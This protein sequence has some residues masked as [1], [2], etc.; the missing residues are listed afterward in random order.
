MKPASIFIF[1][2]INLDVSMPVHAIPSPGQDVYVDEL[3][4]HLG[5]SATN[6]AIV[7]SQLG[8]FPH[9]FG[10]VGTDQNGNRLLKDIRS[11]GLATDQ[12]IRKRG[13]PSG[14]IFLTILPDGERSMY[15][16]RGANVC[17]IPEDIPSGWETRTDL[18]HI[19][20]YAF[21]KSPQRDTAL[22]LIDTATKIHI[23]ISIDTGMDPVFVAHQEMKNI[24]GKLTI[25]ICGLR[26]GAVL[27]GKEEVTKILQ[28]FFDLGISCVAIKLGSEGCIVGLEGR[29]VHLPALSIKPVDTTGSGDAFSAGILIAWLMHYELSDMCVLANGLG[30]MMATY[31]GSI[32]SDLSWSS[33]LAFL[34]NNHSSQTPELK[35]AMDHAIQLI[36]NDQQQTI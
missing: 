29:I 11:F 21:L 32:S 23:P 15:S 9:L 25:C 2:D 17:T 10:S 14:Q 8:L 12:I 1:G 13:I 34:N 6:T 28:A 22:A 3:S 16:F 33:L 7:L 30:A 27:T 4:F 26:E 19:S 35:T 18:L 31:T 36:N 5:G 24:L 20:G